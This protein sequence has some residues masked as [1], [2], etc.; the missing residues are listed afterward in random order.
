MGGKR[1]EKTD[2]DQPR[3]AHRR[4]HT[5]RE[6]CK[7]V[8]KKAMAMRLA[9]GCTLDSELG[10]KSA[11]RQRWA[12][13]THVMRHV[14]ERVRW[15]VLQEL[16]FIE[17]LLSTDQPHKPTNMFFT[18][19]SAHFTTN[20]SRAWGPH[21]GSLTSEVHAPQRVQRKEQ[22]NAAKICRSSAT[23]HTSERCD[24]R[25][26]A[27]GASW[28]TPSFLTARRILCLFA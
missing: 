19:S 25:A 9:S 17:N 2:E 7:V 16:T 18:C 14:E 5:K 11:L 24:R 26:E 10:R 20:R 27:S 6:K 15:S 4:T 22:S 23:G 12:Q 8:V 28:F 21:D 3:H 13:V 1:K